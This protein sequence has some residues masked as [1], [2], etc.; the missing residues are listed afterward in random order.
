LGRTPA[1]L[2]ALLTSGLSDLVASLDARIASLGAAVATVAAEAS[3]ARRNAD[4]QIERLEADLRQ[5]HQA[6]GRASEEANER[7]VELKSQLAEL[8]GSGERM[9]HEIVALRSLMGGQEDRL[10][11][12][13][14]ASLASVVNVIS[15]L[16]HL[17]IEG[18]VPS[19]PNLGWEISGEL[20]AYLFF[21]VRRH[22]PKLVL[23]LGSG[24]STVLFAAAARANGVGRVISIEHDHAH[25]V[26]T[27]Q[28]LEQSDLSAW[29]ELVEAPLVEQR[30]GTLEL[31]W[32][33]LGALLG[34]LPEKI[35]LLFV[36]GPPGRIQPLSRYPALPILLPHLAPDAVVVVDDGRRDDEIRM[37]ELWRELNVEF[38]VETLP[39]LPRSPVVLRMDSGEKR[40]APLR[41]P[42]DEQ[43]DAAE[44]AFLG[45]ER[46]SGVR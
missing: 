4:G 25:F 1:R 26:R 33:D 14:R 2:R 5:I 18:V 3:A 27:A 44:D 28:L 41:R 17:D 11:G 21:L 38:E 40:V 22:R 45:A 7:T 39:F 37:V 23:E 35:G 36:D 29:A 34:T 24:S 19:F 46:R 6:L 10:H 15:M 9:G 8:K 31:Q 16:P 12:R 30:I 42:K 13:L 32:Y 20:A 43:P